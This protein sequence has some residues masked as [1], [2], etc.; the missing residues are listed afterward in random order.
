MRIQRQRQMRTYI[1]VAPCGLS[2]PENHQPERLAILAE[3]KL[4]SVTV[5]NLLQTA[6]VGSRERGYGC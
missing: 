1:Q 6:E 2:E 4:L 3:D 5:G